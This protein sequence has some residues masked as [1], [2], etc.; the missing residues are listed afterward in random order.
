M[1]DVILAISVIAGSA[2]YLRAALN[3]PQLRLGD[4]LGPQ[5]FPSLVAIGLALSGGLLLIESWRKETW[6]KRPAAASADGIPHR[7]ASRYEYLL[8]A[9]MTAWTAAYY[10]AFEPVGY[11]PSTIAYLFG[12]LAVFQKG[13]WVLN[14]AYA[15]AFTAVVYLIFGRLLHVVLPSGMLAM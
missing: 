14:V 4:P 6:R 7:R 5:M 12:L 2:V 15:C 13:R 8:L 1:K 9:G 3:L 10:A 11:V